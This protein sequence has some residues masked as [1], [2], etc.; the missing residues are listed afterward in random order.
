VKVGIIVGSIRE[1]RKGEHVARWVDA[2]ARRRD[3]ADYELVDLKTFDVPLLTSPTHPMAAERRYDDDRVQRWSE[4]VD[5]CDAFVF[6]TPEYNHGVPGALKNAVDSLGP[7]WIGKPIG[8][9]SYGS[10]L[11]SRAVEQWRQIAANFSMTD[12]RAQ[13]MLSVFTDF[14][15]DGSVQTSDRLE[16]ALTA[17]FDEVVAAAARLADD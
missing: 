3:D 11:G 16:R 1:G 5:G 14:A 13:V 10:A 4:A 17:T 12:V 2:L 15:D 9:V 8:F 7:E 6:V